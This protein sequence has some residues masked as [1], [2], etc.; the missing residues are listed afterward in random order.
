VLRSRRG[1]WLQRTARLGLE[2]SFEGGNQATMIRIGQE[3]PDFTANTTQGPMTRSDLRGKWV[4]LFAHPADYT[5]VCTT[6]FVGFAQKAD[7]FKRLGA[8][9]IG[10]SVDSVYSHI[11]WLRDIE[12]NLGTRIPF[13]VI[14]DQDKEVARLYG[15]VDEASGMTLRGVF[16][17]DPTGILRF[18]MYYPLELGR[19]IEEIVRSLQALQT[20]DAYGV[21]MPANWKPGD[22]AIIPP[23]TTV[24][25]ANKRTR[26]GAERWYLLRRPLSELKKTAK[27]KGAKGKRGEKG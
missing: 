26:A 22:R 5:P 24:E 23:P 7:E 14:A 20:A 13:P 15:L 3:A 16:P 8:Q 6:E 27:P 12:E 11:G 2:I 19:S 25:E 9:L 1:H 10:L 18:V 17:I 21:A 4:V